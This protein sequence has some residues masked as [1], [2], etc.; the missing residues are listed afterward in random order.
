MIPLKDHCF[1]D[2][3]LFIYINLRNFAEK[4]QIRT[5]LMNLKITNFYTI[6]NT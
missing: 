2:S 4:F 1:F 6:N 5:F 3:G